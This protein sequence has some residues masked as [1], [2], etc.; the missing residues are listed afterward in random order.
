M[1]TLLIALILLGP[2]SVIVA[3]PALEGRVT[4]KAGI[5]PSAQRDAIAAALAAH[6]K[7]TG[8]QIAVLT[9]TDLGGADIES[10]SLSVAESWKL[11]Q[12]GKDNGVLLVVARDDRKMRIEVGYGLEGVLTD[13][14]C[15]RIVDSIMRPAFRAGDFGGG[16]AS[17]VNEMIRMLEAEPESLAAEESRA[18]ATTQTDSGFTFSPTTFMFVV[19]IALAIVGLALP[20]AAGWIVLLLVAPLW[21]VLPGLVIDKEVG[22]M[23]GILYLIFAPLMRVGF[24]SKGGGSSSGG[25]W[26]SGSSSRSSSSS[27]SSSGGSSF[28]GGG[29][30]FGGGGASGGW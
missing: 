24:R 18:A 19:L 8:N 3:V 15:G 29:G 16:I 6:E 20:G 11:G 28:S 9:V 22:I 13:L 14:R 12:Q 25:G 1:K 27:S 30:R 4:D 2:V 17:A 10:Y 21:F 7:N 26:S 5:M 23:T